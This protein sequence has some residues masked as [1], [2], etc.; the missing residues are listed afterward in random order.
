MRP[1][2]DD[3]RSPVRSVSNRE[4]HRAGHHMDEVA[5]RIAVA[6]SELGH[7]RINLAMAS[8]MKV[9]AFSGRIWVIASKTVAVAK[10]GRIGLHRSV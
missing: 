1:H 7:P 6:V 5:Q 4:L 10:L 3:I 9:D 2:R 8:P